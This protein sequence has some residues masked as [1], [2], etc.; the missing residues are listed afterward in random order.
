M[1]DLFR[2]TDKYVKIYLRYI[3]RE[4]R[5]LQ[6]KIN[7]FGFDE[8]NALMDVRATYA[9]LDRI[10]REAFVI[11]VRLAYKRVCDED[12]PAEMWLAERLN[13]YDPVTKYLWA[14]ELDRKRARLF[15]SIMAAKNT[16]QPVTNEKASVETAMHLF[17]RQF[18]Q[19]ADD[20]TTEA[21]MQAYK[22]TGV[23]QVMWVTM[24]DEKVCEECGPRDGKI[25]TLDN[26]P[27][28]PAHYN[29]RCI[30]IPT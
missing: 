22:D 24:Q 8:I 30:L 17:A 18:R 4:F 20:L 5:K 15:E 14:P 23:K 9:E 11:I 1:T 25:Y 13:D 26:V 27:L 10:S 12:F 28:W 29:C 21:F 2:D 7:A 6:S 16:H 3:L 19:T